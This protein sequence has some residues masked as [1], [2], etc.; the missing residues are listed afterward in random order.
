V[1]KEVLIAIIL[2]FGLGLVITFG[3]WTANRALKK[4]VT[5]SAPTEEV[6]TTPTP[7][8]SEE[9]SLIIN[10][11]EDESISKEEKIEV[12][13]KT[14]PEATLVILY[15]EGE[16]IIQADS[17][18]NFSSEITLVGGA[19]QIEITAY[20]ESGNEI[21]KTISVVYTTAEI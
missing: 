3:V 21:S 4:T 15:Q 20:N 17:Q 2:G 10:S 1:R 5:P 11:P 7:P 18:G 16:K 13:G 9:F 8:I 14:A 19:N 6:V 12:T